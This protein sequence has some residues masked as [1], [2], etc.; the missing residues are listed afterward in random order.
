MNLFRYAV[1]DSAGAGRFY[2]DHLEKAQIFAR[3]YS[4]PGLHCSITDRDFP[5]LVKWYFAGKDTSRFKPVV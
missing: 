4:K 5:G 1:E 2:T 3:E